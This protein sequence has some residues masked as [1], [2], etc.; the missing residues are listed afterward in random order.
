MAIK[1]DLPVVPH[2]CGQVDTLVVSF[3]VQ[4]WTN[5]A[6]LNQ[7][8]DRCIGSGCPRF[9]ASFASRWRWRCPAGHGRRRKIDSDFGAPKSRPNFR[10]CD[11][12]G[13]LADQPDKS[14]SRI[15]FSYKKTEIA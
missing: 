10:R 2:Q 15:S 9:Q 11:A 12:F 8:I 6:N 5:E 1:L 14:A 7:I 13:L 4:W 3:D